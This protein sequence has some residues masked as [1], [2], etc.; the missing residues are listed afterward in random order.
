MDRSKWI[1]G[2][3]RQSSQGILDLYPL[4]S[5]PR[6]RETDRERERERGGGGGGGGGGETIKDEDESSPPLRDRDADRKL[7]ARTIIAR[8]RGIRLLNRNPERPIKFVWV[9]VVCERALSACGYG[10]TLRTGV[11]G[12]RASCAVYGRGGPRRRIK[13]WWRIASAS[14]RVE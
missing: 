7:N 12:P 2:T 1:S 3:F 8:A 9:H 11:R 4:S 6:D 5:L 14:L 10:S 13:N